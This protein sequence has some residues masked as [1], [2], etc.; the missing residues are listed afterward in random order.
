[1]QV[2]FVSDRLRTE[3]QTAKT[4]Q[5][6]YGAESAKKLQTRLDD[7]ADATT[8][9]DLRHAAG[10]WE[11]LVGDRKGQFSCRLHGG[12]RLILKPAKSPP[13]TKPDGGLDWDAIDHV[14][15][16]EVVDYH[17]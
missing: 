6:L 1:M 11:E 17:D 16:L 15:I 5:K 8:L 10:K 13:P 4:R 12:L 14:T 7:L 3:C 2:D 9:E